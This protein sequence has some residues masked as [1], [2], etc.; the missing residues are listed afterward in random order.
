MH[1]AKNRALKVGDTVLVPCVVTELYQTEEFCNVAVETKV[2]RRPDGELERIG[3][4]NT[5]VMFRANPDDVNDFTE[6]DKVDEPAKAEE[7]KA[8]A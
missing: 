1:D 6:L 2:G 3:A 5:G 8:A 4:I 7:A